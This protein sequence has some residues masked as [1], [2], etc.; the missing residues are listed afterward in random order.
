MTR[1]LCI[2]LCITVPTLGLAQTPP[3]SAVPPPPPA[4][5]PVYPPNLE[6]PPAYP[7]G[8]TPAPPL[9]APPPAPYAQPQ[10]NLRPYAPLNPAPLPSKNELPLEG[11]ELLAA[12]AVSAA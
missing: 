6:P 12:V 2:I 9:V 10:P 3:L 1:A 11:G 4:Y 8:L 7:P 5:P